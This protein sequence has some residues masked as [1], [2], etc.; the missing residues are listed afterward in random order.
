MAAPRLALALALVAVCG[1]ALVSAGLPVPDCTSIKGCVGCE[2]QVKNGT[3]PKLACTKCAEPMYKVT[4][5]ACGKSLLGCC[6]GVC[7]VVAVRRRRCRFLPPPQLA[8]AKQHQQ[9]NNRLRARL[10]R[11]H[12]AQPHQAHGVPALPARQ[13][14]QRRQDQLDELPQ[15]PAQHDALGRPQPLP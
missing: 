13:H 12:A 8:D 10:L 3:K 5:G 14:Q 6:G 2:W 11:L 1:L 4:S 15:V 9:K 7:G